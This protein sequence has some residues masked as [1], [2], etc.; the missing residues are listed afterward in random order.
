MY[1][2]ADCDNEETEFPADHVICDD[3]DYALIGLKRKKRRVVSD[4]TTFISLPH[5]D[6]LLK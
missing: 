2:S 6:E 1:L 5:D 3:F 4:K